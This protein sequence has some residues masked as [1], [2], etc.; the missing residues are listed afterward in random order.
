ML[1]LTRKI[2]EPIFIGEAVEVRILKAKGG[3]YRVGI[4]APKDVNIHRDNTKVLT[5][6]VPSEQASISG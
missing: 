3:Q 2:G 4:T 6:K 1:I 5:K